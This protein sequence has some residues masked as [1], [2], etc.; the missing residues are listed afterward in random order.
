MH[1]SLP[2]LSK[3]GQP[4]RDR[5]PDFRRSATVT[6]AGLCRIH[7]GFAIARVFDE[8]PAGTVAPN[9]LLISAR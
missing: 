7:T 4:P 9:E 2:F 3:V 5:R 8:L 6:V 1:R